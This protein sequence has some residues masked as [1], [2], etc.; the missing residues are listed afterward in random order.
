MGLPVDNILPPVSNV[1]NYS[2]QTVTYVR[3]FLILIQIPLIIIMGLDGKEYGQLNDFI[4]HF[5]PLKDVPSNLVID[6]LIVEFRFYF[7][8]CL[9]IFQ[10]LTVPLL[11]ASLWTMNKV[12]MYITAMFSG[13]VLAFALGLVITSHTNVY[14]Q[15]PFDDKARV[16]FGFLFSIAYAVPLGWLEY[17]NRKGTL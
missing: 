1:R 6:V 11:A 7:L 13:A 2:Q 3:L 14:S 16:W 15:S 5:P 12:A 9:V 10:V 4:P 17:K 8:L